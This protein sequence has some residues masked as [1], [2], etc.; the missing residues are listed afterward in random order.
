[1]QQ[2]VFSNDM[3]S[4]QVQYSKG[5]AELT[6]S[7]GTL[8]VSLKYNGVYGMGEKYDYLN[9][10]GHTVVN[11]I[12]EKFCFQGGKTYCTAPFFWTDTGFGLYIDT[13]RS[14]RFSFE[15]NIISVSIPE[16]PVTVFTGKPESIIREYMGLFGRA[17]LPP[18]WAFGTWI[19]A[20]CWNTQKKVEEQIE[21]IRFYDFPATVL[22]IE[23][24][25]DEATFYIWN[26]ANYMPV[27]DGRALAC[28]DFDFSGSPWPDPES[29]IEKLHKAGLHLVLWQIP[30]YKKQG[31]NEIPNKQNDLDRADA[32][33]R[34]LCVKTADSI[35][36]V[37]PDGHWFPGSMIPDFTNQE[38]KKTWFSKRQYLIDMGVDGFKTDGGE[39]I[40]SDDVLFSD[41]STGK[42][43]KNRYARD[44]TI[45]YRNFIGKERVLF[46]RAG[47]SGQ[48]MV[49][50]HWAGDQQ[51]VN[52][53]LRSALT[54]GLSAALTGILFWGFDLAGFAGPLPTQDLYRRAT[55]L[56]CFCP[57]MQWH[58]EPEGGQFRELMPCGD[59]NNERSPWNIANVYHD[60]SFLDEMRF[61]HKLRMNLLPYLWSTAQDCVETSRP[62]LRPLVYDWPENM[63]ACS[64]DDEFLLGDALL[65]SPLL[66]ENSVSRR[67]YLP[68][69]IWTELFSREVYQG[70]Q[71]VV[72]CSG[73]KIPV[74]VRNGYAVAVNVDESLK[75]GSTV[76]SDCM[77]YDR[78]HFL[79]AGNNGKTSFRDDNGGN[80]SLSWADDNVTLSGVPKCPVSWEFI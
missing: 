71:T 39:F 48:H 43:G 34:S 31:E 11:E 33:Q 55:Q 13:C 52:C 1:M 57:I 29:M 44:Y 35:P 25:S 40:Y 49:P 80:F 73:K 74:F 56:A 16:A 63:Q 37:I 3:R 8:K 61:W 10:K 78:L 69:G 12:E 60:M 66:E 36:Y 51:S 46:S 59:E 77:T 24:W 15:D 67:V 22:V 42:E 75:L 38:T 50:I 21:K 5:L 72:V 45:A 6:W 26:G 79:L 2:F 53:E 68:E 54:A 27:P 64:C 30:V 23:A 47:F 17:I 41:G 58:S 18:K 65:V 14:T 4:T 70:K 20:N 9:Q 62:M 28:R 7:A 19:S 76:S 32:I